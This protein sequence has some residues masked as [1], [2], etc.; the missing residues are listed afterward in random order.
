M[1][2]RHITLFVKRVNRK[3][4]R[5]EDVMFYKVCEYCGANIDWSERC[6]CR[7]QEPADD[8]PQEVR[9]DT[10]KHIPYAI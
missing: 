7:D 10:K 4:Y 9:A 5:E 3:I 1:N 8:P 2:S 6:S